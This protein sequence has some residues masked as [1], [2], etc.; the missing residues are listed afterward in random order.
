VIVRVEIWS[1]VVCP[2]CYV[3]KKRFER[4]LETF[5]HREDVEV[6]H[7]SFQLD[8]AAPRDRTT[9]R[10]EGLMRKYNLTAAD[11]DT[12]DARMQ[13][14]AATEGLDFRLGDGVTG[15]TLDAHRLLH[16][17]RETGRQDA[18]LERFFRAYFVEGRSLFDADALADLSADAGLDPGDTRDVLDS[19]RYSDAVAA[20]IAAARSIG[21]T[22]VP[23]FAIAGRLG[24]SG[25]QATS[26]FGDVLSRGWELS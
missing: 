8:P 9:S 20:D 16:L 11:V 1:D 10:R 15:N 12:L 22:G 25:A 3:G 23:F 13:Q 24:V 21:V 18:A 2:W 14:T 5:P 4:A 19:N 7:R 17:A 6:V 26:V